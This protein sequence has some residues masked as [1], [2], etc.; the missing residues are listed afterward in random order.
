[1][2]VI[3]AA[4]GAAASWGIAAACDNRSTR[5]IG[6]LQALAW[7]QVVG[8]FLVLPMAIW[9][10]T[11]SRP[12]G[13]ALAW[14]VVGGVGVSFGLTLSYAAIGRG[15]VSV[16]A[17]VTAIDGALAALASVALG[18]HI[19]IATAA[20][21]AVVIA[22]MLVV[23]HATAAQERAG[24][25]GHSLAAVLLAGGAACGFGIFLLAAIRA[26]N[27]FGDGQLQLI[28][29]VVPFAVVG[30][31]LLVRGN[32]GRPGKGWTWVTA[33]AFL[34]TVG[35]LLYRVAGRSGDVAIPSVLS[36]QFAVFAIIAG[37]LVLG[38]RL[39]RRQ[40]GG[41]AGLLLGIALIAGTHA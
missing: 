5:L 22:G 28:Y 15:A 37:V 10:G 26:G 33:A 9:E 8:F 16:V 13:S 7:V 3:V 1:M 12:S 21:L 11:P 41:L 6:D 19:A 14:I 39:S 18:E 34:Q 30:V 40:V 23:L 36:S 32:L 25:A 24:V 17:S 29:R 35:F 38:E 2:L 20:G 4:L 27:A 31:P